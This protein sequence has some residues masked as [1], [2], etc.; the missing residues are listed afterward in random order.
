MGDLRC[1]LRG[2]WIRGVGREARA[3]CLDL[4]GAPRLGTRLKGSCKGRQ[5]CR[6]EEQSNM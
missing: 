3:V 1:K 6:R 4:G 2:E 5:R